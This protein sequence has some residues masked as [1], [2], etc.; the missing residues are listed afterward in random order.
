MNGVGAIRAY[1]RPE[2]GLRSM[3]KR[4]QKPSTVLYPLPVVM[5]SCGRGA[6]ANIITLAWAGTLCSDPPM[7]GLGIRPSRHSYE[8]IQE[9]GAF[10]VNVPRASQVEWVDYCGTVSGRDTDK[11]DACGF[12]RHAATA[13]D[14]PAIGECPV[15]IECSLKKVVP[16]GAHHLFIGEVVAVQ[17]DVDALDERGRLDPTRAEPVA[18]V[19]GE[20]RGL[21][22][23]LGTFGCSKGD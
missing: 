3:E 13:V 6:G 10:V 7:V 19:N 14:V 23:L 18:Y 8:L 5:V 12:T 20:Y 16:L 4:I 2:G 17:A 1:F 21:G 11:W 9:E 22:D 15:N